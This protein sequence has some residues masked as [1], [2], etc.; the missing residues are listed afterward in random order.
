MNLYKKRKKATI[1]DYS[2]LALIVGVLSVLIPK[3][4]LRAFPILELCL[5]LGILLQDFFGVSIGKRL[6]G[7]VVVT[8]EDTKPTK[9]QLIVRNLPKFIV[10]PEI[11][12]LKNG[13]NR[14]GDEIAGTK[15]ILKSDIQEVKK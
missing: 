14:Y 15:V 12:R 9:W 11:Y 5:V 7:L 8:L 3:S 13:K 6:Q 2:L 1:I 10:Y 4:V